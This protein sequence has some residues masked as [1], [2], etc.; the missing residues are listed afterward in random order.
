MSYSDYKIQNI[1]TY[2]EGFYGAF[3]PS[4]FD[5]LTCI[6]GTGDLTG[7]KRCLQIIHIYIMEQK[8]R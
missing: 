5:D 2:F 3:I 6:E 1:L 7:G 4:E 8:D